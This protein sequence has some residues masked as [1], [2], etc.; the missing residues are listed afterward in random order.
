MFHTISTTDLIIVV[1]NTCMSPA[2]LIRTRFCR[3]AHI[4][5][6]EWYFGRFCFLLV[7]HVVTLSPPLVPTGISGIV[8]A[9]NKDR[10]H[11]TKNSFFLFNVFDPNDPKYAARVAK[12]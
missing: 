2:N 12:L 11:T 10:N 9:N 6:V 1:L 5:L 8:F 7:F 4:E 3:F